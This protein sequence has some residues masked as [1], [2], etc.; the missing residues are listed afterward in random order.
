MQQV[1]QEQVQQEQ[2]NSNMHL[3]LSCL[4]EDA[5]VELQALRESQ[6]A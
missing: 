4:S 1:L 5:L 2:A 6:H 3:E